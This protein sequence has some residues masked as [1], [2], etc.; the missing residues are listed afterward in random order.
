MTNGDP[1]PLAMRDATLDDVPQIWAL[2]AEVF[3]AE[4]WSESMMREEIAGDHRTYLVLTDAGGAVRGYAGLLAV[5]TEADVQTIALSASSRGAGD[6]RRLMNALLDDADARGV[7]EVFL[8]VRAD[9]PVAQRLYT[10]L[11]F[12]EIGVR[13]RY[14]QPDGV[15][16][17]VMRLEMRRREGRTNGEAGRS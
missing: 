15:D 7:R 5:G 2:E 17:V 4:A 9:N 11:G 6:G 13:P 12:A 16:A 8:E 14:Y 1:A 3:G 10:S